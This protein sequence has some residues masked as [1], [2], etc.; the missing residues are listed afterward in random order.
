MLASCFF[1]FG[2]GSKPCSARCRAEQGHAPEPLEELVNVVAA[3]EQPRL[4][5]GPVLA[6]KKESFAVLAGADLTKDGL[7]N[8]FAAGVVR[9][10]GLGAQPARHP[11][12]RGRVTIKL[13]G[14]RGWGLAGLEPADRNQRVGAAFSVPLG[15][16]GQV[17]LAASLQYPASTRALLWRPA[18]VGGGLVEH[19]GEARDV[20]G[21][22]GDVGDDDDLVGVVDHRLTVVGLD[23]GPVAVLHDPAV[24]GR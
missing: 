9:S 4:P 14:G 11:L 19:R 20:A 3:Q 2:G 12:P 21:A 10:A 15:G 5:A 7:H 24:G 17:A 8:R 16:S 18:G 22:A 6:P 23:E 13:L 1:G